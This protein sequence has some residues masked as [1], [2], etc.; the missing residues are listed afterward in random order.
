MCVMLRNKPV[1]VVGI[2]VETSEEWA[3]V[4]L[5]TLGLDKRVYFNDDERLQVCDSTANRCSPAGSHPRATSGREC[6]ARPQEVEHNTES[7]V[8]SL[9]WS[10]VGAR[11]RGG[12]GAA[13]PLA[14]GW[15]A[16]RLASR[17]YGFLRSMQGPELVVEGSAS[18]LE[19]V[20]GE[21][22][23]K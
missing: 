6:L 4:F 5:P 16:H 1:E 11:A 12:S 10:E 21:I 2:V 9:R 17:L 22:E 3:Q 19:A 15:A 13:R 18:R 8:T 20:T 14:A 23:L 7:G